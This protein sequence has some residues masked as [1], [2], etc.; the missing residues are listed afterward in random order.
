MN[1]R[2]WIPPDTATLIS[3]CGGP[4][5]PFT[6]DKALIFGQTTAES[7][8]EFTF[9]G[10]GWQL[11]VAKALVWRHQWGEYEGAGRARG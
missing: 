7:A 8:D 10:N 11:Q 1:V 5:E 9:T 2:Y 4:F 3:R 6:T